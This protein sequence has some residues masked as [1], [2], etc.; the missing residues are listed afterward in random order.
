MSECD[1]LF[2][3]TACIQYTNCTVHSLHGHLP[4]NRH[5]RSITASGPWTPVTQSSKTKSS[6]SSSLEPM[7]WRMRLLVTMLASSLTDRQVRGDWER[8][9]AMEE[10]G[11]G[12]E[13]V[14]CRRHGERRQ[15]GGRGEREVRELGERGEG[16]GREKAA[17][18]RGEGGRERKWC[19]LFRCTR[20]HLFYFHKNGHNIA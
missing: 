12:G 6:C 1:L 8:M 10:R 9:V 7:C 5:L 20:V 16:E 18:G 2:H 13:G 11:L 17:G 14:Q 15:L 4:A 19:S 3:T